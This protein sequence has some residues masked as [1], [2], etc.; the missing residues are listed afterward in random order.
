LGEPWH[1]GS[2]P[3]RHDKKM[4]ERI[5]VI[6]GGILGLA[7]AYRIGQRFPDAGITVLEKETSVCSHQSGHNSGVLHAGLYYKPGSLK[8]RLAVRGIRQMVEFCKSHS[9]AHEICGKVVVA[10]SEEE[11]PRLNALFE[12]GEQ[13]GLRDLRL[14]SREELREIEP[15]AAGLAAVRVPEEGIVDYRQVCDALVR[16]IHGKVITS[17][18]VTAI[19]RDGSGWRV[20]STAGDYGCDRLVTCAGL[21]SD[22]VAALSGRAREVRIVPFRG[23]Y[24]KIRPERQFLVRNLIYPVPDPKF[25]FLGVHFTRLIHGGIEA[26]PNAVLAMSREGYTK[27][28]VNVRDLADALAFPGLW[29][30]LAKYPGMCWDEMRRSFSRK[31]FCASLQRLVPEIQPED[32]VEGGAGVRAQ[33]MT[34]D[35]SLVEDFHFVQGLNEL[36]VV[37]APSPGA[38]ASLAIGEEIAAAI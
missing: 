21:H 20:I 26:G 35:G 23:E 18:R 29:R 22:R 33:A 36:H 6:G 1:N 11:I 14:L 19:H 32:L 10:T 30:F 34:S 24:Y 17:A 3:F 27:T 28:L 4:S 37:N 31:L 16:E 8:A 12:R 13:N 25:P 5:A 9:I 15:H 2:W 7:A 38:T